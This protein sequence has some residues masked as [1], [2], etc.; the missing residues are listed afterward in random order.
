MSN[1]NFQSD[2]FHIQINWN[3]FAQYADFSKL[4]NRN[5]ID[6]MKRLDSTKLQLFGTIVSF[7]FICILL[8]F[9]IWLEKLL[10]N[11]KCLIILVN[12]SSQGNFHFSASVMNLT[13]TPK[14]LKLA[15]SYFW[16][17][18]RNKSIIANCLSFQNT[19][20]IKMSTAT[21][22]HSLVKLH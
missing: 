8:S 12:W 9:G 6:W 7:I 20:H 18:A 5:Q 13:N 15:T 4:R 17:I 14:F 2:N 16:N 10:V 11:L 19:L 1:K 22:L 3:S 21:V